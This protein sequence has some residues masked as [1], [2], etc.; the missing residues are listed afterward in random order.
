MSQAIISIIMPVYNCE[1]LLRN[2]IDSVMNQT[3]SNWQLILVNDGS[4]DKSG[5]ICD[6]YSKKDTRIKSISI[7]NSGP[8]NVS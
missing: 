8:A 1:K 3:A 7:D 4:T 2:S 6:E 5:E